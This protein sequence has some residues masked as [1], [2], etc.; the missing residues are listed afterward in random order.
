MIGSSSVG[1]TSLLIWYEKGYF[2]NNSTGPTVGV[3]LFLKKLKVGEKEITIEVWD[4][5]G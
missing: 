4:T 5:A 2:N 1:K 3:G